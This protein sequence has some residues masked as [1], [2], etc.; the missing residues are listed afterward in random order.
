[1]MFQL[2]PP[3]QIE[4]P[5]IFQNF[6]KCHEVTNNQLI[7]LKYTFISFKLSLLNYFQIWIK[8]FH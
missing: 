7:T 8:M 5:T 3:Y 1:M 4:A 6:N 2:N